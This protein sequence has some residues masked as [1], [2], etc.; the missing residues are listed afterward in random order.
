MK[1]KNVWLIVSCL[2]VL[3]LALASCAPA[4]PPTEEKPAPPTEEKPAPP[5]EEKPAPPT[6]EKEMV[7]IRLTKLDGTVVE[8]LVEKPRYGGVASVAMANDVLSF[9]SA[10]MAFGTDHP[11]NLTNEK[12]YV[13][14]WARGL[15]GTGEVDFLGFSYFLPQFTVPILGES[16]EVPDD[17]TIILHVR[18][19]IH[20]QNK[21]PVNGRE[22][23]ADDLV[24]T[25]DRNHNK[26][27]ESYQ[28]AQ[29]HPHMKP[30]SFSAPDKYTFVMK[31]MPGMM[32]EAVRAAFGYMRIEP[33]EVIEKYGNMKDW[34]NVVGTGP[35]MLED[36]VSGSS[37]TLTRN[38]NYYLKDPIHPQNSLPYLDDVKF[39]V[40]PDKSTQ[41]AAIRTGKIDQLGLG[42]TALTWEDWTQ[43]MQYS[44]ELKWV[45][46]FRM[47]SS[48]NIFM[49]SDTKPFDDIRVRKALSMAVDREEIKR[50]FYSGEA[51]TFCSPLPPWPEFKEAYTP[52]DQLPQDI[53]E[54]LEYHPDKA[55]QLL[56]EA[57]YP[58]GFKT[59]MLCTAPMVD[60][61]SIVKDYWAKVGVEAQIDVK[62]IGAYTSLS[63]GHKYSQL[64]VGGHIICQPMRGHNYGPGLPMNFAIVDDPYLAEFYA[65]NGPQPWTAEGWVPWLE[66]YQPVAQYILGHFWSIQLPLPYQYR[67]W[68][69]W[70]ANYNGEECISTGTTNEYT[71]LMY[72]WL[73]QELKQ[74]MTK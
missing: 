45:K 56:A 22:F 38:P 4:A 47:T 71:W 59:E 35:F 27:K 46:V 5:T 9:D 57:G 70:L 58:N 60:V 65:T 10:H 73:D 55:K 54:G 40:I 16:W 13:G 48:T 37:V 36:Y 53:R 39:F 62:E 25:F 29:L 61:L 69:P 19:G 34:R 44:P 67:V 7:K 43:A 33:R 49:R 66:S 24:Y 15:N 32:G 2:M 68:W 63:Y 14:D 30:V 31:T 11:L 52:L 20:W 42:G 6:E 64:V 74:K 12:I 41:M 17:Q 21:P 18:K 28:Y 26:V 3:S 50:E 8:K 51:E 23:V 1:K 72:I